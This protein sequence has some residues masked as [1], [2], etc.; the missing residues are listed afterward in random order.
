MARRR[1]RGNRAGAL[2]LVIAVLIAGGLIGW[3]YL[4]GGKLKMAPD[5]AREAATTAVASV[6]SDLKIEPRMTPFEI[7]PYV[8]AGQLH[9]SGVVADAATRKAVMA[10]VRAKVGNAA[11][12]DLRVLP[13]P[14]L[15]SQNRAIVGIAVANLGAG[16][17]KDTGDDMVTQARLGDPLELL[18]E[19]DG[20]YRVRMD[21]KYLGWI[22]G[23]SIVIT[24]T[25]GVEQ[26]QSGQQA[27]ITAKFSPV[28]ATSDTNGTHLL[29]DQAVQGTV[30]PV[31]ETKPGWVSVKLPDGRAGWIPADCV[32]VAASL[33]SAFPTGD[34]AGVI[35]VAK[36]YLGL[37]YLWG[38][39]TGRGFDCSGLTQ[40][41]YYMNGYA[42]P[43]DADM[44]YAAGAPV[45]DRSALQPGDLVFFST[46]K[47]G[48]SHVGIYVGNGEYVHASGSLGLAISSFDPKA[49]DYNKTLDSEYLGA[50]R[51]IK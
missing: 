19:T 4:A 17:G 46:Y 34:A 20:W 21:D 50:R 24:D 35:A 33:A 27:V 48:A 25:A 40:F 37:P 2:L 14:A 51:F 18:E 9:I 28:Y 26:F 7:T 23:K 1:R 32:R 10:A 47:S 16:P 38:G 39:T 42:L 13:D 8:N 6:Q 44:Q 41:C 31:V 22:D 36:Q 30:V 11:I 49:P 3:R 43:R 29:A 15:G 45:A 5:Q 12:D